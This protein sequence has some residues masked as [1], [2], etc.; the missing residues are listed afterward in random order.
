MPPA[1]KALIAQIAGWLIAVLS[2]RTGWLPPE[3][4]WVIAAQALGA[5]AVATS[6]RSAWWWLPIHLVFSPL[7]VT[8]DRLGI[9]AH[10]YLVA[11]ILLAVVFWTSFRTQVP[12]YLSNSATI[13][14]LLERLPANRDIRFLDIGSGTG[15]VLI[16]LA[17]HRP[18]S[19]F[20]GIETAPGPYLVSRLM[21]RGIPNL[22]IER[23]D[24]F[25]PSWA[26]YDIVYAFLSPVPMAA[27]WAKA[28][29]ELKPGALLISNSFEIPGAMPD[30]SIRGDGG[31]AGTL[32]VYRPGT[33]THAKHPN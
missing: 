14:A 28:Q 1:L 2:T 33:G 10:W 27:V 25:E 19:R 20:T 15:S 7:L 8:A 5:M 21:A 24:F 16:A 22:H 31:R 30:E 6:L 32:Y 18:G 3:M 26:G 4:H 23:G 17:R 12:L 9:P 29:R 13:A 11:F